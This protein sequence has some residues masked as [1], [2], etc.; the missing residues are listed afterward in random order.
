MS[1]YLSGHAGAHG[2]GDQVDPGPGGVGKHRLEHASD[3]KITVNETFIV[4]SNHQTE[5]QNMEQV[6]LT[7]WM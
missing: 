5:F 3:L 7:C 6:R 2:E 1:T 4:H